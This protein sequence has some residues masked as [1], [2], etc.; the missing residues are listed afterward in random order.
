MNYD[1]IDAHGLV[2]SPYSHGIGHEKG[3]VG[4]HFVY[5]GG[6]TQP[7]HGTVIRSGRDIHY[8]NL[9]YRKF[10][11]DGFQLRGTPNG[12]V[13]DMS[14]VP[15]IYLELFTLHRQSTFAARF[16]VSRLCRRLQLE[17]GRQTRPPTR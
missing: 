1:S 10:L 3:R 13:L 16:L 8:W 2:L 17:S 12:V 11:Q 7:R 14:D 6:V 4:V 15:R 9:N 5:A